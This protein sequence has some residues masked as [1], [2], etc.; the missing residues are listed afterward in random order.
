MKKG[1]FPVFE[2]KEMVVSYYILIYYPFY[3]GVIFFAILAIFGKTPVV[4]DKVI[5]L[6]KG[7]DIRFSHFSQ[8]V[9]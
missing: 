8:I 7:S 2:R 3:Q 9:S 5:R 4:K 1:S 6:F